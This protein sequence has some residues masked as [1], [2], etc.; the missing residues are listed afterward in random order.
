[1]QKYPSISFFQKDE[2][3]WYTPEGERGMKGPYKI[4]GHVGGEMYT[5]KCEATGQTH[6][7][8]VP[9]IQLQRV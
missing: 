8:S 7:D 6:A 1:M 5:I 3:V 9:K 2:A 4:V